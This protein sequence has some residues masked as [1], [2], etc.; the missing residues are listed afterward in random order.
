[1]PA[2]S[3]QG[4][5]LAAVQTAVRGLALT[6]IDNANVLL[7]KFAW[8]RD[9]VTMPAVFICPIQEQLP[10]TGTNSQDDT[11]YGVQISAVRAS[12][13]DV[14]IS[15]TDQLLEWRE[16]LI[17]AFREKRITGI[18]GQYRTTVDPGPVIAPAGF[19]AQI[20]GTTIF[21]RCQTRATRT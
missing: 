19:A 11:T 6:G 15:A 7:R 18:A 12:N 13:G 5:I 1:M 9:G 8:K 21:L 14:T 4:D 2:Q 10:L 3:T 20:D 17:K 16:L